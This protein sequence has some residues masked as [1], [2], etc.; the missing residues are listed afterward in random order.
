[1]L[2]ERDGPKRPTSRACSCVDRAAERRR[3]RR[4]PDP[5]ST[6]TGTL[7]RATTS[8]MTSSRR[9]PLARRTDQAALVEAASVRASCSRRDRAIEAS[10]R[11]Q[12][13]RHPLVRRGSGDCI[14]GLC[15]WSVRGRAV[16]AQG[17]R[18][19]YQG[20]VLSNGNKALTEARARVSRR[21]YAR[22]PVSEQP[23]SSPPGAR[24]APSS[25]ASRRRKP[26]AWGPPRNPWNTEP[27]PGGSSG[28]SAAAVAAGMEPLA[29]TRATAAGSIRKPRIVLRD[30]SGL[31]PTQGRI[32]L[33]H[34]AT[35]AILGVELC[36]SRRCATPAACS[37]RC[38]SR[39]SATP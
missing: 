11:A 7:P 33:G 15:R 36:V 6:G 18:A 21:H 4:P 22:R 10:T 32:P 14:R 26:E 37:T 3:G 25:G 39:A 2:T 30:S 28:G 1:L 12:R 23:G 13:G 8:L 38:G 9:H 27:S 35:R 29:G 5:A 17:S 31:K 20:P 34:S 16:P 19:A 24:T